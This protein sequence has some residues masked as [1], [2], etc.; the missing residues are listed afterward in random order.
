MQ[1]PGNW[2][3]WLKDDNMLPP[4]RHSQLSPGHPGFQTLHLWLKDRPLPPNMRLYASLLNFYEKHVEFP[5]KIIF[6]L[7]PTD[8]TIYVSHYLKLNF[9]KSISDINL[10]NS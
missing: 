8:V 6:S 4:G 5:S 2:G 7:I 1:S 3:L 9:Q 10:K